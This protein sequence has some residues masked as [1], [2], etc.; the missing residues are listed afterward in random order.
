MFHQ[1][2]HLQWLR[3]QYSKLLLIVFAL[4]VVVLAMINVSRQKVSEPPAPTP[5]IAQKN[6]S[7]IVLPHHDLLLDEFPSFYA[8]IIRHNP[9]KKIIFLSPN[10][11]QPESTVIKTTDADFYLSD[12][13]FIA[14]DSRKFFKTP[15]IV[16]TQVFTKEHGVLLHLPYIKKY[17]S[18]ST[19]MPLLL[20]RNISKNDLDSLVSDIQSQMDENTLLII[21]TDFSHYLPFA[22][23][24][25]KDQEMLS[26][27]TQHNSEKILSLSDDYLD[28]PACMYVALNVQIGL[29]KEPELMF[30]GNSA[31]YLTLQ[32]DQPTTS[33]FVFRW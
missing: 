24:E 3:H 20:T 1:P 2:L 11:F 18:E 26:L 33:Y 28:C 21:S 29:M 15:L 14:V 22:E 4:V 10:H 8:N 7:I 16:D 9:V 31:Q 30:H 23:A 19:I 12:E 5:E 32:E 25:K 27:I 13:V 6:T 17:F